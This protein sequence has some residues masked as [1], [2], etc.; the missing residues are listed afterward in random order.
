MQ[1][2]SEL[3]EGWA[4]TRLSE[5]SE[6]IMGQSPPGSSYN[7]EEGTP[8]I[9]GPVEFGPTPF[10]KTVKSKF[11]TKPT[12][13]CK[14][15]DLLICVR[16]ST[17]GRMN[18]AGFDA[19]IGRGVAAVRAIVYQNYINFFVHSIEDKILDSGTG[20][21]FPN[22]TISTLSEI[23]VPFPP[24]P[25]QQRIVSAIEALFA[26]LDATNEKLD[27][28]PEILK[29]F[30]QS[31]L[32]AACEGRL[33]EDWRGKSI[34]FGSE[35]NYLND[36]QN[37]LHP[38]PNSWKWVTLEEILRDKDSLS[39]GIL[40]PGEYDP[41]GIQMVRVLDIGEYGRNNT[42]IFKVSREIADKYKRTVLEPGDV[43]LAI[44]ATVG[45]TIVVP[46]EFAGCNVNR[47]LAVIKLNKEN[48]P[49]YICNVLRSP[50]FQEKF[51]SE[52]IG[53]AQRRINLKDL[54]LFTIPLPPFSEQQE[55]V[56]RVDAL[57][58]FADS[59]EAKVAAAREKTEKLR[60]SILS[61]AFSGEL[62]EIEA[63]IA[64]REGRDYE[65]A[66]VLIERIK[67]ENGKSKR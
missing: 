8:L 42:E 1:Q 15:M 11:T 28:V 50:S 52:K 33:T 46:Q 66:E 13:M 34:D 4:C 41:N 37:R 23:L 32:S 17:T 62:V 55:I 53:S 45:R 30:R 31:V 51:A 3:P 10:S 9:N 22:V 49:T 18:I 67:E 56:R 63:E 47:A 25:E 65:K 60:Q 2:K 6:I 61:K 36:N 59:V 43:L 44:M 27:R 5:V 14:E 35:V 39:Y 29:K 7:Q 21:T 16:G 26:R 38:I 57:F 20:S 64:R 24:L 58:A 19:C 12:K 54:R 48:N 40:K